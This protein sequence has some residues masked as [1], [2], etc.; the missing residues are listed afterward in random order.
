MQHRTSR[1]PLDK[2]RRAGDRRTF[3]NRQEQGETHEAT[4][5]Q[6]TSGD[7]REVCTVCAAPT[8]GCSQAKTSQ[9]LG[10]SPSTIIREVRRNSKDRAGRVC[11]PDL[12]RGPHLCAPAIPVLRCAH[13]YP[14]DPPDP[15]RRSLDRD[16]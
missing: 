5:R 12:S 13:D 4:Y 15:R 16:L 6:L 11:R 8:Q 7:R 10:R 9:S 3:L 14:K 2:R 1:G